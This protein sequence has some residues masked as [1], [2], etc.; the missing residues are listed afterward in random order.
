M[1]AASE[2]G[3]DGIELDIGGDYRDTVLWREGADALAAMAEQT[4]CPVLAFC[5]GACWGLSPASCDEAVRA[6]IHQLLTDLC[7]YAESLG[8]GAILVPVTP[9]GEGLL[10]KDEQGRWIEEMRKLASVAEATG[11]TLALENVGRGCGKSA[12]DLIR[13]ADGVGSPGVQV[14][15]DIGNAT[16]FGNDPVEEIR[17]LGLR[18]AVVHIKDRDGDLLGDGIVK[19]PEC[20][21]ALRGIGYEG[22][23]VLETPP[24]DDPRAAAAHNLRYLRALL[25]GP[26]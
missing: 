19:I 21:E 11:V 18:V 2:I 20:I 3:F 9:G 15:Y 8:A 12:E 4:G 7:F 16:A 13:L 10:Y 25:Q 26:L 22:D 24:T 23:L 1:A 14:Y 17:S 6:E 5:A